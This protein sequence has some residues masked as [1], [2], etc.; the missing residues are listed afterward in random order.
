MNFFETKNKTISHWLLSFNSLSAGGGKL[1]FVVIFGV[2]FCTIFGGCEIGC[3]T[4]VTSIFPL[5]VTNTFFFS[6]VVITFGDMVCETEFTANCWK[7]KKWEKKMKKKNIENLGFSIKIKMIS[8][9][10][11]EWLFFFFFE[12]NRFGLQK[13][14]NSRLELAKIWLDITWYWIRT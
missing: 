10:N 14:T 3:E 12:I 7:M 6:L 4:W 8:F 1:T 9:F 13:M 2:T 5:P 11:I